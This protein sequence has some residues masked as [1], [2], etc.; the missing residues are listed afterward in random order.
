MAAIWRDYDRAALDAQ[1]DNRAAVPEHGQFF[2][3]WERESVRARAELPA[4]RDVVYGLRPRQTI[5]IFPAGDNAPAV[6]FLHGG[7][8]RALN[9]DLFAFL[10]PPFV[11]AGVGVVLVGY[12]L[13]PGVR[14]RELVEEVRDAMLWIDAWGP[15]HGGIDRARIVV[16]GH[17]AGGHLVASV[18]ATDWQA[19]GRA[20]GLIGAC[21][22]SGLYELEPVRLG[23]LNDDLRLD[24]PEVEEQSPIRHPPASCAPLLLAVGADETD[25]FRAQ[26]RDFAAAWT[27]R[28]VPVTAR[29]IAGCNHF[30]VLDELARPDAALH[31]AVRDLALDSGRR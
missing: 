19:R 17:S 23:V 21:A 12:S 15:E 28:G 26:Q 18:L 31:G 3:R 22:I 8:W 6:V 7:Y 14:L 2:E 25:E 30:S 27:A 29:E 16:A 11:E 9:K 13:C 20:P 5:D 24:P 4:V 1:Y 10:A